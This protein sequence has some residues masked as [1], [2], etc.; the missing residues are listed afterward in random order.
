MRAPEEIVL[1]TL[2]YRNASKITLL[3]KPLFSL[4]PSMRART[5]MY[6]VA[7]YSLSPLRCHNHCNPEYG[8][9]DHIG[10]S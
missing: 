8:L 4:A 6:V 2:T 10:T 9:E 7:V 5:Y 3:D 1:E